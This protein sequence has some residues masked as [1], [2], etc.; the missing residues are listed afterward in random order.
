MEILLKDSIKSYKYQN[1]KLIIH[2]SE[3][4]S[5]VF[6]GEHQKVRIIFMYHSLFSVWWLWVKVVSNE[7]QLV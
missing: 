7:F 2:L 4:H 1:L 5:F 6:R 3:A